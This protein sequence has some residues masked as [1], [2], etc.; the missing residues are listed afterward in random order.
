[1]GQMGLLKWL[2]SL[3]INGPWADSLVAKLLWA[4]L[5]ALVRLTV[6]GRGVRELRFDVKNAY[7]FASADG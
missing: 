1:M 3:M 2:A 5:W 6:S 7:A 4:L